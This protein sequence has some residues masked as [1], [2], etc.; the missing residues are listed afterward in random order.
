MPEWAGVEVD[1]ELRS[2]RVAG[3]NLAPSVT[4]TVVAMNQQTK[5]SEGVITTVERI[6]LL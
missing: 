3:V 2:T 5:G 6:P 4:A 1:R